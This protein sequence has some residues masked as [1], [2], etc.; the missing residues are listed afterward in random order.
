MLCAFAGGD[1]ASSLVL[2]KTHT[3]NVVVKHNEYY[4]VGRVSSSLGN[5][6]GKW[7]TNREGGIHT[8]FFVVGGG[9]GGGM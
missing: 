8:G 3:I 6:L 7:H 9:G 1:E 5:M 2:Q 4:E